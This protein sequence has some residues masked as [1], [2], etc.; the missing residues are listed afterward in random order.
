MFLQLFPTFEIKFSEVLRKIKTNEHN[1]SSLSPLI[2]FIY[3]L[4]IIYLLFIHYLLSLKHC[5]DTARVPCSSPSGLLGSKF[6]TEFGFGR[7]STIG[8]ESAG[9]KA[10]PCFLQTVQK[11]VHLAGL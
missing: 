2:S 9:A 4:F 11:L 7:E 6:D 1:T 8:S 3:Y 5:S 10:G